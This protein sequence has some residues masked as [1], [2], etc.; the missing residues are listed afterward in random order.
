M[1]ISAKSITNLQ[2]LLMAIACLFMI[3]VGMYLLSIAN[4]LTQFI[5]SLGW[6][7]GFFLVS[8]GF[9]FL[10]YVVNMHNS[11]KA[12]E[13]NKLIND[14]L[15]RIENKLGTTIP[16]SLTTA[17]E[18]SVQRNQNDNCKFFKTLI[19][20]LLV[21]VCALVIISLWLSVAIVDIRIG[22]Q[23]CGNPSTYSM[24]NNNNPNDPV[25]YSY[26]NYNF[27]NST[28]TNYQINNFNQT[29]QSIDSIPKSQNLGTIHNPF[30]LVVGFLLIVLFLLLALKSKSA[31]KILHRFK[32]ISNEEAKDADSSFWI[33]VLFIM[34]TLVVFSY[35]DLAGDIDTSFFPNAEHL[36]SWLMVLATFFLLYATV[37]N[38][39]AAK[40]QNQITKEQLS[41]SQNQLDSQI[42]PWVH[43]YL[44][45]KKDLPSIIWMV[46]ENVG[47]SPAREIR[48][49]PEP[50]RET[51][52]GNLSTRYE[53]FT[54]GIDYLSSHQKISFIFADPA[55]DIEYQNAD[56]V[57]NL[58]IT[59]KDQFGKQYENNRYP[60]EPYR[61][62]GGRFLPLFE[63]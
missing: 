21:F 19:I 17:P 62:R 33:N 43:A 37:A 15:D 40:K 46:I 34:L 57:F 2:L 29:N 38:I 51:T 12:E 47:N 36:T 1:T 53:I 18:I 44:A 54:G 28:T 13:N 45:R 27:T 25:N 4:F 32:I 41:I 52:S 20:I 56:F 11:V 58:N 6:T 50:D 23:S 59:Y 22:T 39:N 26:F 30:L 8:L 60:V 42:R 35:I 55:R 7:F 24:I 14:K 31:V 10:F 61:Y 48:F 3:S 5:G 63:E 16:E 9:T 49:S